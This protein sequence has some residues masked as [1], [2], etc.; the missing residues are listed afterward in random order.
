MAK[1]R[2]P[3]PECAAPLALDAALAGKKIRCPKCEAV[4]AV[5]EPSKSHAGD[6]DDGDPRPPRRRFKKKKQGTSA[7]VVAGIIGAVVL[8]V[9]GAAVGGYLLIKSPKST[10]AKKDV[11]P[12]AGIGIN[13]GQLVPEIDEEDIDGV[14][15]KLSD[16]RGKVVVLDF[17]GH[18]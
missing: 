18:W 15:F 3:C 4:F 16:Y 10:V 12:P 2:V 13:V 7:G 14:K 6:A 8:L 9:G 1:L 11:V 17:W 5:P